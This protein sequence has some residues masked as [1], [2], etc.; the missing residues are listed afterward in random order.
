MNIKAKKYPIPTYVRNFKDFRI[1]QYFQKQFLDY[2][3]G[4]CDYILSK[5]FHNEL[6]TIPHDNEGE[7]IAECHNKFSRLFR[8]FPSWTANSLV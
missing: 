3:K 6:K 4:D 2:D 8:K 1:W 5:E 7:W